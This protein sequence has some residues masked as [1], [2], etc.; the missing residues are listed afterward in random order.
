MA[1]TDQ[2]RQLVQRVER[3]TP[4][5]QDAIAEALRHELEERD[6]E[7]R[8]RM[9]LTALDDLDRLREELRREGYPSVDVVQLA[10]EMRDEL[11]RRP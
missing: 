8:R 11:E 5:E 7:R 4:E 1:M 3:L 2:L 9:G 10:W 6:A